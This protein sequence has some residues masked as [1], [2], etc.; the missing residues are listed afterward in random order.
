MIAEEVSVEERFFERRGR[1]DRQYDEEDN[2]GHSGSA[3]AGG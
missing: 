2:D 3:R 1:R